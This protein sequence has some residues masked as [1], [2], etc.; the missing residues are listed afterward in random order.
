MSLRVLHNFDRSKFSNFLVTGQSWGVSNY[1]DVGA[2]LEYASMALAVGCAN[3]KICN[4][5]PYNI[6]VKGIWGILHGAL[7]MPSA[8]R[9]EEA[10]VPADAILA[11]EIA[12]SSDGDA[13]LVKAAAGVPQTLEQ[14]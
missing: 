14:T 12:L 7:D 8:R 9:L 6:H 13:L 4:I 2:L 5:G 3:I 1:D 11:G 10:G